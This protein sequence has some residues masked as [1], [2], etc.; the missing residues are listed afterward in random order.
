MTPINVLAQ[1]ALC[2]SNKQK[3]QEILQSVSHPVI[4]TTNLVLSTKHLDATKFALLH[5]NLVRQILAKM[6]LYL[7]LFCFKFNHILR[8]IPSNSRHIPS[9]SWKVVP[10]KYP[11]KSDTQLSSKVFFY[12]YW[13]FARYLMNAQ[14][15]LV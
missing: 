15:C 7:F 8:L 10:I 3:T 9:N 13:H 11:F 12:K 2:C 6:W 4:N 1:F 14:F 5:L